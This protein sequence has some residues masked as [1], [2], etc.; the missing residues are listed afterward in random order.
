MENVREVFTG[1]RKFQLSWEVEHKVTVEMNTAHVWG[2]RE[3]NLEQVCIWESTV[4]G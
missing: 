3:A 1:E 2:G 4:V